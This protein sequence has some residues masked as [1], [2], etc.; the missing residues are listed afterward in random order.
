MM[1]RAPKVS[2]KNGV[3]VRGRRSQPEI[4]APKVHYLRARKTE[5]KEERR[6]LIMNAARVLLRTAVF[7]DITME[8]VARCSGLAK[9]SVYGY[10]R[11]KEELFLVLT[12]EEI[13]GWL[14]DLNERLRRLVKPD[15]H[16]V[17]DAVCGSVSAAVLLTRLLPILHPVLEHNIDYESIVRVK[18]SL[19]NRGVVTGGLL[20]V[21]L[22]FL[23]PGAGSQFF[24]LLWA[25]I[26]GLREMTSPSIVVRRVLRLRSMA[27]LRIEFDPTLRTTVHL[28][29]AGMKAT[30][31]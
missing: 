24:A 7:S 26:I 1:S 11:T 5:Q 31:A 2:R 30:Y 16:A 8:S 20:E 17:T 28:L 9:G 27:P 10:F 12:E 19:I 6:Q 29:L 23:P 25:V 15:L 14:D 22:P 3:A 21:A 18:V 13:A 4:V